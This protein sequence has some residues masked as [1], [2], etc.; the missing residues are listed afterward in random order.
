MSKLRPNDDRWATVG[1][2]AITKWNSLSAIN[3]KILQHSLDIR[4]LAAELVFSS[5]LERTMTASPSYGKAPV[6]D[7]RLALYH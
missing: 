7:K 4:C 1:L 5:L 2:I 6:N 3:S